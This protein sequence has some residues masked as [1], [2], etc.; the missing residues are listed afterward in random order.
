MKRGS[1]AANIPIIVSND[2]LIETY[3]CMVYGCPQHSKEIRW[4]R[5]NWPKESEQRRRKSEEEET[6]PWEKK[7]AGNYCTVKSKV[8]PFPKIWELRIR[9]VPFARL[10]YYPSPPSAYG[11]LRVQWFS[12]SDGWITDVKTNCLGLLVVWCTDTA[13]RLGWEGQIAL[14]FPSELF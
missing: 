14:S 2:W 6:F 7:R 9:G 13:T 5:W 12:I 11:R 8:H 10:Q 1:S 4:Q 3:R